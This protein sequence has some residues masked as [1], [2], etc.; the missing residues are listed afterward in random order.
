MYSRR[1]KELV[2][3]LGETPSY[4]ATKRL[5]LKAPV[6]VYDWI[7][8]KYQPKADSLELIVQKVP[9]LSREWLFNGRGAMFADVE[10]SE[11]ADAPTLPVG[12]DASKLI[13]ENAKLREKVSSLEKALKREIDAKE[14]IDAE[15]VMLLQSVLG[16]SEVGSDASGEE[17]QQTEADNQLLLLQ[18]GLEKALKAPRKKND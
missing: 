5:G 10:L 13:E 11:A 15:R 3:A 16:K 2:E 12:V 7:A 14:K 8:E 9:G 4:F 1:I 17:I 18:F 6:K